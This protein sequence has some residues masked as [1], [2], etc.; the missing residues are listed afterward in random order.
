M[1]FLM[2]ND[3]IKLIYQYDILPLLSKFINKNMS[4]YYESVY[5]TLLI[6]KLL[7]ESGMPISKHEIMH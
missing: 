6:L 5:A 4:D 2:N 1:F 3:L 7:R